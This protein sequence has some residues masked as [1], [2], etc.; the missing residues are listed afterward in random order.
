MTIRATITLL[1][2]PLFLLLAVVNGAL[3]YLQEKAEIEQAL[4]DQARAAVVTTA[5]FAAAIDDPFAVLAQPA[6]VRALAAAVDGLPKIGA[7]YL[8]GTGASRRELALIP[9]SHALDLR[10]YTR[11]AAAEV[12]A[13]TGEPGQRHIVALAPAGPGAFA[14]VRIDAE[15]LMARLEAKLHRALAIVVAAGVIAVLLAGFVA[16]R[17]AGDLRISTAA[18]AAGDGADRAPKLTIREAQDLADAIRLM[19]ASNDAAERRDRL[20]LAHNDRA[21]TPASAFAAWRRD[22]FADIDATVA[23]RGVAL[24]LTAQA[25]LGTFFALWE[26]EGRA[27]AIVGHCAAAAPGDALADALAA[28]RFIEDRLFADSPE[29]CLAL[30]TRAYG[31]AALRRVAWQADDSRPLADPLAFLTDEAAAAALSAYAARNPDATPAE[32]LDGVIAL[33]RPEGAFA[34]VENP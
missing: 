4:N 32:L 28:R 33:A 27:M 3:L 23:G 31:I 21:R 8:V 19:Q 25:P 12:R 7:L 22:A 30:A 9:P 18:I 17:I 16:R 15:P 29:E 26:S 13:M 34:A 11:P 5:E 2:L 6:R 20:V 10:G 24:R 14:A 1:T